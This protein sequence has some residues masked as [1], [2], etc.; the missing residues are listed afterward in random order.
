M[1]NPGNIV[2]ITGCFVSNNCWDDWHLF[3]RNHGYQTMA[4]AWPFKKGSAQDQRN[5]HPSGN[6]ALARLT[7][8]ELVSYYENIVKSYKEKPILIGHSMGGLITQIL[9]NKGLAAAGIAINSFHP[10]G[11][12]PYKFRQL[13]LG[14]KFFGLFSSPNKTWLMS[15]RDWQHG[16]VNGMSP[17]GQKIA[18]KHYCIPE[19]RRATLGAQGAA[20]RVDFFQSHVPLLFISGS[21]DN[22]IPPHLSWRNYKAYKAADSITDYRELPGRTHFVLGQRTWK[23]D[24]G[25]VLDW[26]CHRLSAADATEPDLL[27]TAVFRALHSS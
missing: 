1:N 7:F 25:Y 21:N 2:F 22:I 20:A 27:H 4:P 16:F 5:E 19:S 6:P 23:E 26:L 3:F 12:F 9:V 15:F 14:W 24:A 13:R 18:Y 10:A 17:D 11:I 8:K